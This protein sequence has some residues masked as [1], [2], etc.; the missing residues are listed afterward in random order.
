VPFVYDYEFDDV[1]YDVVVLLSDGISSFHQGNQLIPSLTVLQKLLE[2]KT[3]GG[4]FIQRRVAFAWK[5]FNKL[6]WRNLDDFSMA[7]ISN[8]EI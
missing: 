5:E 8:A 6:G 4:S 7:G 3:I 2:F 1:L